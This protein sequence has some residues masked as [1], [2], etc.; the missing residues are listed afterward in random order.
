MNEKVMKAKEK[1]SSWW[2]ELDASNK[3][4]YATMGAFI[5]IDIVML[6]MYQSRQCEIRHIKQALNGMTVR[7]KIDFANADTLKLILDQ[8]NK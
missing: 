1:I 2:N 5:A 7:T 3:A 6:G 8:M 4:F